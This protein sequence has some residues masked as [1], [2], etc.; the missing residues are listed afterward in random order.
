MEARSSG[1][2][3]TSL[4]TDLKRI[5]PY[6]LDK[7]KPMDLPCLIL[8]HTT[9]GDHFPLMTMIMM[10]QAATVLSKGMEVGGGMVAVTSVS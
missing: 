7:P 9:M 4:L 10:L 6:T 2:T 5:I 1:L 3:I 8:W